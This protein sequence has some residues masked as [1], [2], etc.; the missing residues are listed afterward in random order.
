MF[1]SSQTTDFFQ[2]YRHHLV[3]LL[4]ALG[5][6]F[7]FL[8]F[9]DDPVL[10]FKYP[11]FAEKLAAGEDI[12]TRLIDL[13]PFYLYL[14]TFFKKFFNMDWSYVKFIQ[15]LTGVVTCVLLYET[16][17]RVFPKTVGF[18][19]AVIYALYGNLI[20]L[21]STLEPTVFVLLFNL[22]TIYF[23]LLTRDSPIQQK[24]QYVYLFLA[25]VFA[26]ISIITKPSFL[27]FLPIAVTWLFFCCYG[28]SN[29]SKN[30]VQ[31]ALFVTAALLMVMP[32][33]LRNYVKLNDFVLVTA[34]AG[35][36]FYRGNGLG[37]TVLEGI[38]LPDEGF[39]EEGQA[40]PDYAHVLFR[41]TA[42]RISG[43][44]LLPSESSRFWMRTTFNEI[45]MDPAVYLK[46]ELKKMV[47]FFTDYEMH[48]I[49]PV[50]K[51]Y[52]MSLKHPFLRYGL[53]AS[54]AILGMFLSIPEFKKRFLL[55]GIVG[56]YLLSGMLFLV[57]SRYR[58]PAVP[59]LCLFAGYSIYSF[60]QKMKERDFKSTAVI[61]LFTGI[62]LFSSY[63]AFKR[64][65]SHVDLWQKATKIHYQMGSIPL[66]DKG[67]YKEAVIELNRCLAILPEFSPAYNLRGKARAVLG[68]YPE[69]EIDFKKVIAL[70]P[71]IV[72]GYKNLGF[73]YLLQGENELAVKYLETAS[74]LSPQN[75]KIR[76]ALKGLNTA[77]IE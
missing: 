10:F 9:L 22:L 36:V 19:A 11:Y 15:S 30:L 64:E 35:K 65:I 29:S 53:I 37:S 67:K 66:F 69:A 45:L 40:E 43:K 50:Y 61:L 76:E 70:S 25:G 18:L 41:D 20:I 60:F 5:A 74:R 27:L 58:T 52:K 4:L 17:R 51:E 2:D 14:L 75:K 62:L 33:T 44:T 39:A 63:R 71:N 56:V 38:V 12:G 68:R 6:R 47:Y 7:S 3:I 48:Y 42:S 28:E 26:G 31:C 24:L 46:R 49:A 77:N 32:I 55:Y 73:L 16:G 72:H 8:F 34:D 54:F 13:S 21:E 59:Y 23:L 1:S 57:Q